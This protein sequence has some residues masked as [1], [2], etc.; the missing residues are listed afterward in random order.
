MTIDHDTAIVKPLKTANTPEIGP[1]AV[2]ISTT[3]DWRY[4]LQLK[5]REPHRLRTLFT[6]QLLCG[7]GLPPAWS[8]VGPMVGAPYAAM[9]LETLIAW[10]AERVL[11]MGWC[12]SISADVRIGDIVLPTAAIVDEG[13]SPHYQDGADK[14]VSPDDGMLDQIRIAL[15]ENELPYLRTSVWSTDAIFRE[16][17]EKVKFHQAN[18]VGAVDMETSALFSVGRFRNISVASVL[19]VSDDL[20]SLQWR[21]GF[22]DPHF[23]ESRIA[24]CEVIERLCQPQIQKPSNA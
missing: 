23:T 8:M 12:G 13:T 21:P 20:S 2:M 11:F 6:S 22:K 17:P 3:T 4:L 1:L 15:N 24:V 16:T 19:V 10:G 14:T 9:V 5:N 18:A 7:S